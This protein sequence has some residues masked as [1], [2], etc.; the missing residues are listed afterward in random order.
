MNADS[1]MHVSKTSTGFSLEKTGHH[2]GTAGLWIW[3]L[4]TVLEFAV[5]A[6]ESLRCSLVQKWI[7]LVLEVDTASKPSIP[8]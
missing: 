3:L 6:G 7:S 4:L 5:D 1:K 2:I 8:L